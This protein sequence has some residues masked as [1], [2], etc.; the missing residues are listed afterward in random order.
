MLYG[1]HR[2]GSVRIRGRVTEYK[3][4][5]TRLQVERVGESEPVGA[6]WVVNRNEE[7]GLLA[8]ERAKHNDDGCEDQ[9]NE[10]KKRQGRPF[11]AT[12]DGKSP[13]Y[14]CEYSC[15]FRG[16]QHTH[17]RHPQVIEGFVSRDNLIGRGDAYVDHY[18]RKERNQQPCRPDSRT[19][20]GR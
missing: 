20:C 6:G 17:Q 3:S 14:S 13:R 7:T 18:A 1:S 9:D 8:A 19:R 11:A 4:A 12:K 5:C 10:R 2:E 16:Q 15:G